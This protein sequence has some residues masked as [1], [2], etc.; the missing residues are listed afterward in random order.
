MRFKLT[1]EDFSLKP[2]SSTDLAKRKVNEPNP[3]THYTSSLSGKPEAKHIK[4][5]GSSQGAY[6]AAVSASKDVKDAEANPRLR[7]NMM[8]NW[9]KMNA[10]RTKKDY[11]SEL[12]A[13][14]ITVKEDGPFNVAARE[15][16]RTKTKVL[17]MKDPLLVK[18]P[19]SWFTKKS[20]EQK[21]SE[22]ATNKRRIGFANWTGAKLQ[23]SWDE[24]SGEDRHFGW[25]DHEGKDHTP[26]GKHEYYHQH[27]L[28]RHGL[29][30]KGG[31]DYHKAFKKGWSRY[32]NH[33][34]STGFHHEAVHGD[35]KQYHKTLG[36]MV[37]HLATKPYHTDDVELDLKD[38]K[39]K[40][41]YTNHASSK[42]AI[43]HIKREME[44]VKDDIKE[45]FIL[46][47][48]SP[49]G[50]FGLIDHEGT[51]HKSQD[52]DYVHQDILKRHKLHG[53]Y[54]SDYSKALT[55]IQK[56][57]KSEPYHVGEVTLDLKDHNGKGSYTRHDD[58]KSAI[59]HI[60][61]L[62][63]VH[64]SVFEALIARQYGKLYP[65][66]TEA[67]DPG[68]AINASQVMKGA[69]AQGMAEKGVKPQ[70]I[71]QQLNNV[72]KK[73]QKMMDKGVT[74][75]V[76]VPKF[77]RHVEN[78]KRDIKQVDTTGKTTI[79]PPKT[80]ILFHAK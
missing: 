55:H 30:G 20:G 24:G 51:D 2:K 65:L 6:K 11:K 1:F 19:E 13:K 48:E 15:D 67:I 50:H 41:S 43:G 25:V 49:R 32:Y 9:E 10:F 29:E 36:H 28:K 75:V 5:S 73:Y 18:D 66:A 68:E 8:G 60:H 40:G 22:D 78:L 31:S 76:Q 26:K 71:S 27:I 33:H 7:G 74:E 58:A 44:R 63:N 17:N 16:D 23:E 14:G 70:I 56:H 37:K 52:G 69:V 38:H 39:G 34:G 54:I 53:S 21:R 57:L 62:K 72:D 4:R 79:A 80:K 64:E 3:F 42:H 45:G 46:E 12:K 59:A 47:W 77:K 35:A 61:K